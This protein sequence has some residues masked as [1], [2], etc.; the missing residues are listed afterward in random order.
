MIY[1]NFVFLLNFN[2]KI[3]GKEKNYNLNSMVEKSREVS[4]YQNL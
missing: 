1:Y 4:H 3:S 2:F